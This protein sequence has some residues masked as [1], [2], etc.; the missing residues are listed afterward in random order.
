MPFRSR[1]NNSPII[2]KINN[3]LYHIQRF[4]QSFFIDL[5]SFLILFV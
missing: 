4:I 5:L 2:L 3:I 1:Q